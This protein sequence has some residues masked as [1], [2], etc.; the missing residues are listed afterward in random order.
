MSAY[1]QAPMFNSQLKYFDDLVPVLQIVLMGEVPLFSDYLNFN[2]YGQEFLLQLIDFNVYPS[3][4]LTKNP[5]SLLKDTDI[6]YIYTSEFDLW[7]DTVVEQYDFI[8]DA[9]RHV[10]GETLVSREVPVQ[11]IVKNTYS[12]GVIIYIN[13][14]STDKVYEGITIGAINYALGGDVQ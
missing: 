7:K 2:S 3:F 8:N 10:I 9:L 14:T 5:S 1:Y 12:N 4:V 6:E 13:Y 11:G